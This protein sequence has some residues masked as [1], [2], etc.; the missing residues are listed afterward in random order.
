MVLRLVG[1]GIQVRMVCAPN[2]PHFAFDHGRLE[3][4]I[5]N[6]AAN[7][8]DAMLGGGVL[9]ISSERTA[10][11]HLRLRVRDSGVG[12]PSH[13]LSRIFEPFYTTKPRERGTGLGLAMVYSIVTAARGTIVV[14]STVGQGTEFVLTFPGLLDANAC[15]TTAAPPVQVPGGKESILLVEDEPA[16]R[17]ATAALL[18]RAGYLVT[19]A[20]SAA[21]AKRLLAEMSEPPA[22]VLTDVVMPQESGPELAIDLNA[23]FPNIRILFMS[24]YADDDL[25]IQG[26]ASNSIHFVAKP[27]SAAELLGAIRRLLDGAAAA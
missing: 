16:V 2:A 15:E 13:V 12:M 5:M 17:T 19:V 26:V 9:T 22:L 27:F 23:R 6:L 14:E 1:E 21:T 3:Q 7:A 25:V 8:R 10:D 4:I 20:E 11:H 24:G 18:S